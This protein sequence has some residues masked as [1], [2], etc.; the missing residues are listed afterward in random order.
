MRCG[1]SRIVKLKQRVEIQVGIEGRSQYWGRQIGMWSQMKGRSIFQGMENEA[2][3][4]RKSDKDTKSAMSLHPD[5]EGNY[6]IRTV[7][8]REAFHLLRV[9]TII[10]KERNL[11][12]NTTL[13]VLLLL[14]LL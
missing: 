13:L 7:L 6:S 1:D 12:K 8:Q 11:V 4:N 2:W 9:K 14:T 5:D 10:A 3:S